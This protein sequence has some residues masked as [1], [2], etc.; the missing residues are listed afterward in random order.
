MPNLVVEMWNDLMTWALC[1]PDRW[2]KVKKGEIL[3]DGQSSCANGIILIPIRCE[4]DLVITL[5]LRKEDLAKG[6]SSSVSQKSQWNRAGTM[7]N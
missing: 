3:V 2:T 4:T 6:G 1:A 5:V 7:H